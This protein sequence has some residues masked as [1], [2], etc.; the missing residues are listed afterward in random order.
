VT[1]DVQDG[2]AVTADRTL[3]ERALDG[4]VAVSARGKVPVRVEARRSGGRA[5]IRLAGAPPA[6]DALQPPQ[7]GTMS[8]P[9]GRALALH[10]ALRVA[11]ALGGSLA[12]DG[13]S[14]VLELLAADAAV[15]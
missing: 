5:V 3:L 6:A 1:L 10:M 11:A 13:G 7:K 4:M 8:D 12:I 14:Y 9:S 15:E 2:L